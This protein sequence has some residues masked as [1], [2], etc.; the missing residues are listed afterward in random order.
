LAAFGGDPVREMEHHKRELEHAA[1]LVAES[2]PNVATECYFI[3]F[4][5]VFRADA[6]E[7]SAAA[8]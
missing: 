6:E 7:G 2:F 8:D 1:A 3:R 5:G 4:D